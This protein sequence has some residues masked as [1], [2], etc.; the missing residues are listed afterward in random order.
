MWYFSYQETKFPQT[1]IV[2]VF[3]SSE[4][5]F[6]LP[7][8]FEQDP[9]H[10]SSGY[11]KLL[12]TSQIL[13]GEDCNCKVICIAVGLSS[14]PNHRKESKVVVGRYLWLPSVIR[15]ITIIFFAVDK[16]T[17]FSAC[18]CNVGLVA[19][20][21]GV[22]ENLSMYVPCSGAPSWRAEWSLLWV[23][24]YFPTILEVIL[25]YC[26]WL[27]YCVSFSFYANYQ[28]NPE[29]PGDANEILGSI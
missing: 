25:N 4:G 18:N 1:A 20:N 2:F 15:W 26:F 22:F 21:K 27:R 7:H 9:R 12:V 17:N 10:N 8:T 6:M 16:H 11:V 5:D 24:C 23:N 28:I 29:H 14:R 13:A 19:K 3:V